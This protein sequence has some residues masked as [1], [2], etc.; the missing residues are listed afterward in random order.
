MY[1]LDL[2]CFLFFL[3]DF[4]CEKGQQ[5]WVRVQLLRCCCCF[6]NHCQIYFGIVKRGKGDNVKSGGDDH[7]DDEKISRLGGKNRVF[8]TCIPLPCLRVCIQEL[9]KTRHSTALGTRQSQ[10]GK[11]VQRPNQSC[12]CWW[13]T[14]HHSDRH[15]RPSAG[16][17]L[18]HLVNL[19]RR[20]GKKLVSI[21][22][23]PMFW[24]FS[25]KFHTTWVWHAMQQ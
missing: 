18:D 3:L 17:K 20:H 5:A 12:Q 9:C 1:S 13:P 11:Y 2:V 6:R 22:F 8:P 23:I 19:L 25:V 14:W 7:I 4:V 15:L 21:I 24:H 10:N 16:S